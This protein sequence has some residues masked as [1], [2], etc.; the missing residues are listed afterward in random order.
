M[1]QDKSILFGLPVLAIA[2]LINFI[3]YMANNG[4]GI[5]FWMGVVSF[6]FLAVITLFTTIAYTLTTKAKE[7]LLHGYL[8]TLTILIIANIIRI[9]IMVNILP[10][11]GVIA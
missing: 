2:I 11:L 3:V 1:Q 5:G 7:K 8:F 10:K 9:I 4:A 6:I